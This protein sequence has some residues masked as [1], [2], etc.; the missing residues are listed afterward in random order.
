MP[1]PPAALAESFRVLQPGGTLAATFWK[2]VGWYA[3]TAAAVARIPGAPAFPS[4]GALT[5]SFD[6]TLSADARAGGVW[7]DTE[8]IAARYREAGFVNV[9]VEL[10]R[11][12]T[13]C[14]SAEEY[15]RQYAGMTRTMMRNVWGE[16]VLGIVDP[17]FDAALLEVM[18]E[19]YGE[20]ECVLPWEAYCVVGQKP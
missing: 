20:G 14:A 17:H 5:S 3:S 15:V 2:T 19:M 6:K 8:Y 18:K 12:E 9:R 11:T 4:Y 10:H 16:E 13:R 7:V 1:D